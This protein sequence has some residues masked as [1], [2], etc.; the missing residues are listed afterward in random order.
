MK[1]RVFALALTIL[2]T[3]ARG[4]QT[5]ASNVGLTLYDDVRDELRE[6]QRQTSDVTGPMPTYMAL[7]PNKRF[8]YLTN[9]VDAG[10][11]V[12]LRLSRSGNDSVALTSLGKAP[13]KS[14]GPVHL[15]VTKSGRFVLVASYSVGSITVLAVNAKGFAN[16]VVSQ[17]V[18]SGGSHVVPGRQDGPHAHCVTLSPDNNYV[19]VSD[20]G[21]DKI[22]QFKFNSATGEL[23]ANTPAFVAVGAGAMPRHMAFHPDG[24]A[25]FLNTEHSNELIKFAYDT[26]SGTLSQVKAVKTTQK[27]GVASGAVR[28]TTDGRFVVVSNRWGGDD[29]LVVFTAELA[30]VGTFPTTASGAPRDFILVGK[31]LFVANENA[32]NI[33]AFR[34]QDNGELTRVKSAAPTISKPQV[35]LSLQ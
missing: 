13:T 11:V 14:K 35:L 7:S 24:S 20:L 30:P 17:V 16:Q 28:V 8:L 12:S 2:A 32:N 34:L 6:L 27:T 23:A 29:S 18:F 22:M 15:T 9:E 25:L 21:N 26:Q 31:T 3:A 10:Q 19:F 1:L 4:A 33:D 5:T